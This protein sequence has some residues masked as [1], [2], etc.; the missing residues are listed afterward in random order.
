MNQRSV[1]SHL[2]A[3]V[4]LQ[5]RYVPIRSSWLYTN[6]THPFSLEDVLFVNNSNHWQTHLEKNANRFVQCSSQGISSK[7]VALAIHTR[8]SFS[9]YSDL[10]AFPECREKRRHPGQR[11]NVTVWESDDGSKF[12]KT[13]RDDGRLQWVYPVKRY[14]RKSQIGTS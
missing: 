7:F 9:I 8:I 5:K 1:V 10:Q 13:N 14:F 3:F 4:S 11:Q 6:D 12:V 2:S